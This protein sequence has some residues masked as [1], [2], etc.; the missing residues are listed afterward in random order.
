[1]YIYSISLLLTLV[2]FRHNISLF[3][4]L[5]FVNHKRLYQ[6]QST[7][8]GRNCKEVYS[9]AS[10]GKF[11]LSFYIFIP[12]LGTSFLEIAQ[13]LFALERT[14]ILVAM[15]LNKKKSEE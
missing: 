15:A 4:C 7:V 5:P 12:E 6:A 1:M 10:T 8:R 11:I 9:I 13:L 14:L 2:Y 3:M